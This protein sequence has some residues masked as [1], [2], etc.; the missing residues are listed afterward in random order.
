MATYT[1]AIQKLYVAYFNRPA[2]PAGLAF[3]ADKLAT[4]ATTILGT[5]ATL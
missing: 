3:Y 5:E 1:D 4:N 2:D